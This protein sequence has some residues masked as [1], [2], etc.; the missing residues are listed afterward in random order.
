MLPAIGARL[1]RVAQVI[2]RKPP[3]IEQ[4]EYLRQF[5][6]LRKRETEMQEKR[7]QP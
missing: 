5:Q 1:R 7:C 2:G 4:R 6:E 3:A